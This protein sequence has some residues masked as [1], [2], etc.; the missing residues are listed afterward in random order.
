MHPF[1]VICNTK[2]TVEFSLRVQRSGDSQQVDSKQSLHSLVLQ[3]A[4]CDQRV[5]AKK[6]KKK[7]Q[8]KTNQIYSLSN[9]KSQSYLRQASCILPHLSL[10]KNLG[11][12]SLAVSASIPFTTLPSCGISVVFLPSD[13]FRKQLRC[14][15]SETGKFWRKFN[16]L[17]SISV[18]IK[19]LTGGKGAGGYADKATLHQTQPAEY[20]I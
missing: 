4:H 16:G 3:K 14:P 2:A 7:P 17:R 19:S 18:R 20:F 9:Y 1:G 15:A 5:P 11:T 10:A 13:L 12:H 8:T 6:K